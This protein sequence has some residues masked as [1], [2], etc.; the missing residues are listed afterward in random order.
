MSQ[1]AIKGSNKVRNDDA[2]L[3]SNRIINL[4]KDKLNINSCVLGSTGKKKSNQYSG[5]IDIAIEYELTDEHINNIE[6]VIKN[7]LTIDS[8]HV[9]PITL[10]LGLKILSFGYYHTPNLF[11]EYDLVQVD[12][13]FSNDLEYSKFMY[14]SPNYIKNESDFKGLYRTNLLCQIA[15]YIPT[16]IPEIKDENDNVTDFWKY[17]LTYDRGL[18]L[19]HKTY[20][21]KTKLLKNPVTVKEDDKIIS[22]DINEIIKIILGDNATIEDTNSFET[23]INYIFSDK[24]KHS[25]ILHNIYFDYI[26]DS[27]HVDNKQ[28]LNE[29]I[30]KVLIDSFK[31]KNFIY[32]QLIEMILTLN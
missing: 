24:F 23:L 21:G 6:N 1:H 29:Y 14:H 31:D 2:I 20:K 17:T 3:I 19:T 22:T 25:N 8:E 10:N 13:M 32:E 9:I 27:R 30:L 11:N 7:N 16:G 28:K 4:L 15:S 12:L 18:K 5:D 26:K